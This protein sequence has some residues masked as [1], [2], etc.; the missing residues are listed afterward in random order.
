MF[1]LSI[2]I[3]LSGNEEGLIC[4]KQLLTDFRM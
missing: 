2:Y 4:F 3:Y 1:Y